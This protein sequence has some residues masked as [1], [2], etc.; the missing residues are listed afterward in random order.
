MVL[1]LVVAL[2]LVATP[3]AF[4]DPPI[5]DT[6]ETATPLDIPATVSTDTSEATTDEIEQG[7]ASECG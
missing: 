7:Y 3:P 1:G 2:V 6:M 4:A 5:N